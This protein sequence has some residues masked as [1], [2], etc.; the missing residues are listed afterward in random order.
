[1]SR[2]AAGRTGLGWGHPV[3]VRG[4][5]TI[6]QALQAIETEANETFG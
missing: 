1:V 3:W 5:V 6:D 2:G 4:D